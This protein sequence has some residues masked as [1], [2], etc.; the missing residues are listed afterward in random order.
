MPAAW[1]SSKRLAMTR[2]KAE[3]FGSLFLAVFSTG[4]AAQLLLDGM[5]PVQMLGA[6]AAVLGSLGLAVAVRIWPQ[7][8]R[9]TARD[10]R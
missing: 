7:P 6:A 2:E 4:L 9:V 10:E 1:G 3:M 5:A 8:A